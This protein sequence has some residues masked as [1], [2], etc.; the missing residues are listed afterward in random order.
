MVRNPEDRSFHI[1]AQTIS[2]SQ[3]HFPQFDNFFL[4]I[5]LN[6]ITCITK[7][8]L[9]YMSVTMHS[10]TDIQV[11]PV[12]IQPKTFRFPQRSF[13]Q[14]RLFSRRSSTVGPGFITMKP[15][16]SRYVFAYSKYRNDNFPELKMK[17]NVFQ[18][19]S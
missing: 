4:L 11:P 5:I 1:V 9:T 15:N 16:I 10:V 13:E 7:Y 8:V 6:Q 17:F 19:Y 14:K 3:L 2:M 12:P 18:H